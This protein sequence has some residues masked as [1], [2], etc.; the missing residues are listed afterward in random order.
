MA[1]AGAKVVLT[2]RSDA[3]GQA[4]V[5]AIEKYVKAKAGEQ[6]LDL[7]GTTPG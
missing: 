1:A 2:V 4:A 3:K 7:Q 6:A 5:Q